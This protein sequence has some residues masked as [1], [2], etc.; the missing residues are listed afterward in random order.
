M[1]I[2]LIFII[3]VLLVCFICHIKF[4]GLYEYNNDIEIISPDK[5]MISYGIFTKIPNYGQCNVGVYVNDEKKYIIIANHTEMCVSVNKFKTKY[6]D[7]F[8]TLYEIYLKNNIYYSVWE[9]YL[10]DIS[11]L[12]FVDIPKVILGDSEEFRLYETILSFKQHTYY[13]TPNHIFIQ[14]IKYIN[15]NF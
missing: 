15:S 3:I 9:R 6:R 14:Q 13:K 2:L 12:L 1:W 11:K 10:N 4:G 5:I 8:P 7:L